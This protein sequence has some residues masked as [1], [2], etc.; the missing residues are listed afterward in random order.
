MRFNEFGKE[1]KIKILLIHGMGC[2][3]EHSF[4][5]T[6]KRLENNYRVIVVSLDGYDEAKNK[7]ISIE[8]EARKIAEYIKENQ[9]DSIDV[10][11]GM[12]MGGFIALDLL[13]KYDLKAKK[14]ILDSGYLKPWNKISAKI[15]SK[16]VAKGFSSLIKGENKLFYKKGMKKIMGYVFKKEDLCEFA[17]KET[18]INSEYSCLR[19]KLEN[20]D[21]LN[22][23]NVEY[24]YGKKEKYMIKGMKFLKSKLSNL[25]EVCVGD[26]G[27]AEVMFEDPNQYAENVYNSIKS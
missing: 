13:T 1:N 25:K 12:S 4:S 22:E 20:I 5:S 11:L 15:F 6:I 27:H 26:Y 18:L 14:L 3:G 10:V 7:F 21:V 17:S 8:E 19:Y 2:T 23:I 24:W 9:E 16:L